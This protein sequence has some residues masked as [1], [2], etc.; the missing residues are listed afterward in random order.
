MTS[1]STLGADELR[2]VMGGYRDALR[3]HQGDINRLNVYPVPDGDTGTNMA[4]TLEAVVSELEGVEAGADLAA[5]CKAIGH[6]SLMG[7]RGNSGVILSQL[8]RGMSER[9]AEAGDDGVGPVV[10]VDAIGHAADLA[11]RAVVRP[12]EGT[13]LTVAS[14]AATGAANGDG[15]VGVVENARAEAADALARTPEM[16]P[17]LAQ[18]GVVDAGGTGY[19]LLLD[20][21]L[22]VLDGR[23]LP[24]PSGVDAPD[25]SALDANGL[26]VVGVAGEAHA[27]GDLRFEVMYFLSAPDDSVEAFKEVWA[28]IGDSI[29]VVGGDGLWNCHIHTNDVGAAVEAGVDAGRPHRIRVTDLDEQVEEERWVRESVGA[30]GAGP[31]SEGTGPP[32]TTSVVA[33]VS[34]D[35]IGRIFRSLGVHHLVVGGQ[36]MN[37]ATADLVK[38]VESVGSAEVVILP[39][40]KNIRP[41]ADQVD[42]L[43]GKTVRVVATGSI[44]EGFAALL[45]YDPA[46]PA[47]ANVASMSDS[48]ARVVPAEVT[49]AVRDTITDAGE[50]HEG[51]YIGVS[52]DGVVAVSDNIVVCT[53]LLLSR[54][55]QPVHELVTL[56]EGEG[57]R[58]ADTRRIEE[59][60][61]E[62]YPDVAL[63]VH[64]GGQPLYPYL[65]G[66][67]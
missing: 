1:P 16:L 11:R 39:N 60:L 63:E 28:G 2:A 12:V 29:V 5:V 49:R 35:G 32:P 56:I 27:I 26:A 36:T 65:L 45:A 44:V 61:S 58:V 51:D 20:A 9:M 34:G 19:L 46:A 43:C 22:L 3:L 23:P 25:L 24:E 7:A 52:R 53:R 30:P 67:E 54:L 62:E 50:V 41:V 10:L 37:P 59:W 8:L 18:A 6:G 47:D 38:A 15:L 40:N 48:A 17:V 21:F 66:I 33:V 64:Q 31:S 13:I 55:L 14:A 4:L 42:A 57:A